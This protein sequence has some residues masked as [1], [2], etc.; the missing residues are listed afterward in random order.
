MRGFLDSR[1]GDK[2]LEQVRTASLPVTLVQIARLSL[3]RSKVPR[4][5]SYLAGIDAR[6]LLRCKTC[7][8]SKHV[9]ILQEKKRRRTKESTPDNT[10][11]IS[12]ENGWT[13]GK[14]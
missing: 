7:I 5:Q 10:M 6:G 4:L 3:A 9:S 12:R 11:Q 14:V 8:L 13:D 1:A 2:Y